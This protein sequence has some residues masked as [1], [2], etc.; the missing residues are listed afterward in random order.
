M[1]TVMNVKFYFVSF[2][3]RTAS[4]GDRTGDLSETVVVSGKGKMR[5]MCVSATV[6]NSVAPVPVTIAS[7]KSCP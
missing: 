1:R 5:A 4:A 7:N 3:P 2:V 6:F